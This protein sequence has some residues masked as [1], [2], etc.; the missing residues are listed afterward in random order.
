MSNQVK[1]T[2][3]FTTTVAA[4]PH[5]IWALW[6][7]VNNWHTW[8]AGIER[9]EIREHFKAGNSFSLTPRGAGPLKIVLK[10][11]T[12]GEEFSDEAVV[13]FGTIRNFHKLDKAGPLVLLTHQIEASIN[14][15]AVGF[16]STEIWPHMQD[17]LGEA[18]KN[19]AS[20]AGH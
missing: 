7:D 8:D 13:P 15:E 2:A 19:I 4:S 12:Q 6:I 1:F 16:F 20:V 9:A 5:D 14:E 17:G 11:V 10:T 18:V 3:A